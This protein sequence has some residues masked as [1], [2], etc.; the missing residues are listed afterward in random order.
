MDETALRRPED[1][2]STPVPS[3]GWRRASLAVPPLVVTAC[4]L[5]AVSIAMEDNHTHRVSAG[6]RWLPLSWNIWAASYGALL[7]AVAALALQIGLRR[8]GRARGWQRDVGW[9]GGLASGFAVVGVLALVLAV[10]G[11]FLTNDEAADYNA[12][13]GEPICEGLAVP[14]R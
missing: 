2:S 9:Q 6:C 13:H 8:Y 14:G 5:F 11:V 10:V 7:A 12:H 3:R 1:D 4:V